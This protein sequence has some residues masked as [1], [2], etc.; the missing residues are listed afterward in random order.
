LFGI[1][2]SGCAGD[3][4]TTPVALDGV[5]DIR[6]SLL[7][8][9]IPLDGMWLASV[10]A[11]DDSTVAR[12]DFD[13]SAWRPV[14]LPSSFTVE[15][16][17]NEGVVF[18]RLHLHLPLNVPGL[19]GYL[20]HA[21]SEHALYAAE[22]GRP[23]V[24]L[25]ESGS[26]N[27]PN[28]VVRHRSPVMFTLPAARELVLTWKVVNKGYDAGGPVHPMMIGRAS[29]MENM[30]TAQTAATF[31]LMGLFLSL[32]FLLLFYRQLQQDRRLL[33]LCFVTVLM[34][35][36]TFV[37][38]DLPEALWPRVFDFS[39]H[40]TL[41]TII[42]LLLISS[43]AVLTWVFFPRAFANITIGALKLGTPAPSTGI[44]PQQAKAWPKLFFTAS[45]LFAIA[46]SIVVSVVV[47]AAPPVLES[48]LM[49][50]SWGLAFILLIPAVLLPAHLVHVRAPN[51]VPF[52]LGFWIVV[53][54]G[55]HDLLLSTRILPAQP[56]L[57]S[58]SVFVFVIL[59]S[60][61]IIRDHQIAG[62]LMPSLVGTSGRD[63]QKLRATTIAMQASRL[64]ESRFLSDVGHELR[65]PL[66]SILGYTQML[67]DELRDRLESHHREFFQTIRV[68][69]ER[70]LSLINDILD[71]VRLESDQVEFQTAPVEVR[72]LLVDIA[73]QYEPI[74]SQQ[75]LKIKLEFEGEVPPVS[76]DAM[77]LRQVLVHLVE[78]AL[79][80]TREG[81][82][83]LSSAET[84]LEGRSAVSIAVKD[85]G[86]GISTDFLPRI[87][88]RFTQEERLFDKKQGSGLGLTIAREL[89]TRMG[90]RL[91]V[92]SKPEEGATFTLTLP[93]VPSSSAAPKKG[94]PRTQD[95]DPMHKS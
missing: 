18:Y 59:A 45:A 58:I 39:L 82:I 67:E 49:N 31:V 12:F 51:A 15:G 77:R 50:I 62:R 48:Y 57:L 8:R 24:L 87:F 52:A 33:S 89:I 28:A 13:D 76:A 35:A 30:R 20:R 3:R 26:P 7:D 83:T 16:Y 65:S 84:L 85:T 66:A 43:L 11:S 9:V 10:T 94:P 91:S 34:A 61:T 19:W 44:P 93:G 14:A 21:H 32:A 36:Y 25:T 2:F 70:L 47:V 72:V 86:L 53:A 27:L 46:S 54:G 80:F 75:N 74:A 69:A 29:I 64:V 41:I 73:H 68:S 88:E 37:N 78:N 23:P 63:T 4:E 60:Y 55:L 5:L 40:H 92:E 81:G 95:R 71:L 38:G 1:L 42:P 6:A 22:P 56:H 17:P 90:G 79:R